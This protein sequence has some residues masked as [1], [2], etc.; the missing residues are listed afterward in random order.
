MENTIEGEILKK[1]HKIH[2]QSLTNLLHNYK[3]VNT[4]KLHGI[5]R[6]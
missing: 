6:I 3:I 2:N 1:T 5:N 4:N